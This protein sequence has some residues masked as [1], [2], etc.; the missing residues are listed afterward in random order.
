[1]ISVRR[2]A[3][4]ERHPAVPAERRPGPPDLARPA[5][6]GGTPLRALRRGLP[7]DGSDV[8]S[9]GR[10]ARAARGRRPA[11][12]RP[13]G[14]AQLAPIPGRDARRDVTRGCSTGGRAHRR[15]APELFELPAVPRERGCGSRIAATAGAARRRSHLRRRLAHARRLRRRER[16]AHHGGV[17]PSACDAPRSCGVDLYRAQHPGLDVGPLS[18]SPPVRR[19]G[20]A[21]CRPRERGP[22]TD[23]LGGLRDGLPEPER[24]AGGSLARSRRLRGTCAECPGAGSARP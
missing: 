23:G 19:D 20:S 16:I 12:A 18:V 21:R 13:R 7:V 2:T 4:P 15:G 6:R 5:R 14:H 8:P 11:P 22:R 17:R 24:Q 3:G 1:M 9:S 10:A